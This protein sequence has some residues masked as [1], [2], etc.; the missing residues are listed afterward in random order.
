MVTVMIH[1][2]RVKCLLDS[3]ADHCIVSS[4]FFVMF[5]FLRGELKPLHQRQTAQGID[6]GV[7]EYKEHINFPV[8]FG[9][10]SIDVHAYYSPA[11]SYPLVIG[12]DL[13]RK[14][15]VKMNF[16][17]LT[18][19]HDW[20]QV[21]HS[22]R[23]E[24][25]PAGSEKII[26]GTIG[27]QPDTSCSA[28]IKPVSSVHRLGLLTSYALVQLSPS[29]SLLPV[30]VMNPSDT[31]FR[32]KAGTRIGVL[33][34]LSPDVTVT[35]L[36]D[37][38]R[39]NS[40][41]LAGERKKVSFAPPD[42]FKQLFDFSKSTF[43]THQQDSLLSLL[44]KYE[45][46]FQ[47]PGESLGCSTEMDFQVKLKSG[48]KPFRSPP[49]RSNPKIRQEIDKQVQDMLREGIIETSVSPYASPVVMVTKSDST[50]RFC[51]D[52]R[53]LNAI[54]EL[55]SHPIQRVD[56]S[57][58]SLGSADACYFS[59]MD[60]QSGYWQVPMA[61]DSKQYTAFT[62][63]SGLFQFTRMPFGL[64]NAPAV[65]SRLMARV[66][67]GLAW[68]ICLVYLDD[69]IVFSSDFESHLTNLTSV[70]D[71][72]RCANLK[73]K[74]SKSFFGR[75]RIRFL[76]HIV[77]KHGI[78]PM[79]D[80]CQA[81]QEFKT[82]KKVKDVRAFL[83][84]CGYY[85]KFI[86]NFAVIAGPLF[87]TLKKD[88][89]FKW[90]TAAED[91]FQTLKMS[92]VNPPVLAY[93][94]YNE[95]Y[96][97]QADA[98]SEAVGM[99][100]SQVQDGKE[101]VIA[102]GGKRF[103]P[104]EK[105]Y[106][107]TEKEALAIVLAFRHF[108]P[109][110][111]GARTIVQ[112]DHIA[113]QWL[114]AQKK[115]PPR[116][117]RWACYLSQFNFTIGHKA[118]KELS[119]ADGLSRRE[120]DEKDEVELNLDEKIDE[121]ILPPLRDTGIAM[122]V[123]RTQKR[124]PLRS[125]R[126][127]NRPTFSYPDTEWSI[128]R[129][130]E[131]QAKDPDIGP[132][133]AYLTDGSLPV[134]DRLARS[135]I[136]SSDAYLLSEDDVLYHVLDAKTTLSK[137]QTD[138][139][140]V[141]LVVPKELRYDILT[142]VHGDIGSGHYGTQRTYSTL[143][144]KYFWQGMYNDTKNWVLSCEK[145]NT[146]KPPSRYTKAELCPIPPARINERWAMDIVNMPLTPRGN[147]CILTFT[148]YCT[149]YVEAFA[150]PNS[151]APTLARV[152]VDQICFRYGCPKQLLSDLGANMQSEIVSQVSHMLGIERLYTA[153][154]RPQTD[155]LL[156]RFNDTLTKN[157]AMYV[158]SD[159][160]DWDVY[161]KA[162]CYGYNTSVCTES[163]GY[164]P[165]YLMFGK[166][167]QEALD[168]VLPT[169][170][171]KK[172]PEVKEEIAKVALA[173][174][175]ARNNVIAAQEKMKSRYDETTNVINFTIGDKVWANFPEIKVGG[176]KK[177]CHNWTGPFIVTGKPSENN[178]QLAH[179]HNMEPLKNVTHVN[180]LKPYHERTVVP[181]VPPDIRQ[182]IRQERNVG[183]TMTEEI[184]A[185]LLDQ[186]DMV[187]AVGH[188][189]TVQPPGH[190]PPLDH[191]MEGEPPADPPLLDQETEGPSSIVPDSPQVQA[192][193]PPNP[194]PG[195]SIGTHKGKTQVALQTTTT[196]KTSFGQG[197][198]KATTPLV[199]KETAG[200]SQ[201]TRSRLGSLD[202]QVTS[203]SDSS[204][205]LQTKGAEGGL[206]QKQIVK[207]KDALKPPQPEVDDGE[208][209]IKK[210]IKGRRTSDD[211]LEYLVEW[212]GYPKTAR[213]YEPW[214]NLNDSAKHWVLTH[215][216]P[217]SGKT[218]KD[219]K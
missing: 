80:K 11:V 191:V 39:V 167:P 54:T 133:V 22:R 150:L 214:E 147:R 82:P 219:K 35:P 72:I 200:P 131:S 125:K 111:R 113:L 130:R 217:V 101:R 63:H 48:A 124:T 61:G 108:D 186:G 134:E 149:R 195:S 115:T 176:S 38:S 60:L 84:L 76:G 188:D 204:R 25:I 172:R 16:G 208:Y 37:A 99:I 13:L 203:K 43:T 119:N 146:R 107:T 143:R 215:K 64:A 94:N 159:H 198:S 15:G 6:G 93:P 17:N 161:L 36:P 12:Y 73:V 50:Y 120:Y 89:K 138:D 173:R 110:L 169:Q 194:A 212:D 2:Q 75:E 181:P 104:A 129:V 210:I 71:R 69:I 55:D 81:V 127:S 145:C 103:S 166:D 206:P 52:F 90:T 57:L 58:E 164:T 154:Y 8:V 180:K 155:G 47:K 95:E 24:V 74:P 79:P 40:V 218:A 175:V 27:R 46:I 174:E 66:L 199:P 153:P 45:D 141:C 162:V 7:I 91:A 23:D 151:Q 185:W 30:K 87:D 190:T 98:S 85:R 144:L 3:G 117:T 189:M 18:V 178:V 193:I 42:N 32:L 183:D 157:L 156:E 205:G 163:T 67:Q 70:F 177:F 44:W 165:Y 105:R 135:V 136:L 19:G 88:L 10:K 158:N 118:G 53:R 213:T 216:V 56:D 78:E 184:P 28:L 29:T 1:G 128:A 139:I 152:L 116:I 83:G 132:I 9:G 109:Y 106:T 179:S 62:T 96:L 65:F 123:K 202:S 5:P 41:K 4:H 26:S 20:H 68:D 211:Q 86:Q 182:G 168:T 21:L 114:F 97:V 170:F 201:G 121:I 207:R 102:Y 31:D 137:K 77:S 100:L 160:N 33:E 126:S 92:L 209:Q 51:V 197:K 196:K 192:K 14:N 148:E 187:T 49:Y 142:S 112:T 171:D 122:A 140:R 34:I 59:T